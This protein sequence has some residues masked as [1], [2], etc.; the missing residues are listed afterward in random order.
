MSSNIDALRETRGVLFDI[1]RFAIH[2][3][4]GIRTTV[5]FKGCDLR[6]WWCHN[7]EGRAAEPELF[8]TATRCRMCGRCV[9][10][11]P[12]KCHT[13]DGTRH[14]INREHCAV[15][16]RCVQA[17]PADALRIAGRSVTAGA[18]IDEVLEDRHY[19]AT[20][21]GGMTLSGGEPTNQP[22]F[23]KAL[24]TLAKHHGIHTAVETNG[25]GDWDAYNS[26]IGLTDVFL[27]DLKQSEENVLQQATGASHERVR[28]ILKRLS[29][30]GASIIIRC[31]IIP[32]ANAE[33]DGHWRRV[34]KIA[35]EL[36][37]VIAIEVLAYHRLWIGKSE[38]VGAE[39]SNAERQLTDISKERIA[40]IM[41]MLRESGKSVERG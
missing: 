12:N 5:F 23:A 13:I 29:D 21:S 39:V 33:D 9:P 6:C 18:V 32:Q 2:D 36:H 17:C 14:V 19:Y 20:S 4:P 35:G 30:A 37:G 26:L 41:A 40:E 24:L 28:G 22:A 31:P 11:C 10:A 25:T 15:C 7:P 27:F 8:F 16:G 3:G 38:G 1:M 34:A